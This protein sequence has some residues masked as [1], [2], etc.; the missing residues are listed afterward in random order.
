MSVQHLIDP[1]I[2]ELTPHSPAELEQ[3]APECKVLQFARPLTDAQYRQA[4]A[5]LAARP[6]VLLRAYGDYQGAFHDLEFL[7][8]F[9]AVKAVQIDLPH[10]RTHDGLR[11]LSPGLEKFSW[12]FTHKKSLSVRPLARFKQLASL[13]LEGHATDIA[14][15]GELGGLCR[16]SLRSIT[17]PDLSALLPLGGLRKLELRLGGTKDLALL[18]R[19]QRLQYLELWMVK[20]LGDLDPVGELESLEFLF[21]QTLKNVTRLPGL[22]SLPRLRRVHL[23][24]MKS[25]TDLA[26]V[27]EAPGLEELLLIDM[28]QLDPG[29]LTPF[30][31]H[32]QLRA[33]VA[34]FNSLRKNEAARAMFPHLASP[35]PGFVF[36]RK[37]GESQAG[38]AN[39]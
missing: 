24:T 20:G 12:G 13:H 31:G 33:L 5:L 4:A 27:S 21:L 28:G 2:K 17:L 32:P 29:S 1:L 8:F 30:I 6:D 23:E 9:P 22:G 34:G 39:P 19:F 11:H 25:L 16:L 14:A 10:L 15:I 37:P 35:D 26:P 7:R 38:I 36:D 3:L 18:P